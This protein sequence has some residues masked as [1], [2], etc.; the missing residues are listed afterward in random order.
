M[1][2]V[3][4]LLSR[5][6]DYAGLFPP[7]QLPLSGAI[8]EFSRIRNDSNEWLVMR[9]VLPASRLSEFIEEGSAA[10]ADAAQLKMPWHISGL[11]RSAPSISEAIERLRAEAGLLRGLMD[12]HPG[13][14]VLDSCELPLPDEVTNSH[15][16]DLARG[17]FQEALRVLDEIQLKIP[18]FW[19]VKLDKSFEHI[20]LAAF[21]LNRTE[22]NRLCLKFRTGGLT[23]DA[24]VSPD[25][26]S[27]AF[28]LVIGHQVPFKLTAGLHQAFR[29]FDSQ[30]GTE[31]FGFLNVFSAAVLGW[32][33]SLSETEIS[34]L[35]QEKSLAHFAFTSE[36]I[37]WKNYT[38]SVA[39]I[40]NIRN[41]GLK[42]FGSCS[43]YEPIEEL[44]KLGLVK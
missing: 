37:T 9:F 20:A 7:A 19:E 39:E 5:S 34:L 14:I 26:L 25:V 11:I 21:H 22:G 30:V 18:L 40:Q 16:Q 36:A 17:F 2:S 31:L 4:A 43:F 1:D 15:D 38:A 3:K 12:S 29:H 27:R 28:R 41:I 35:L 6:L 23:P 32:K 24:I 13:S 42:S 33:Y 44:K 10:L 8:E